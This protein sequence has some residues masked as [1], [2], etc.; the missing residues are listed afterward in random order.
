MS[1]D[2]QLYLE[3]ARTVQH[4]LSMAGCDYHLSTVGPFYIKHG[5]ASITVLNVMVLED[6]DFVI[7]FEYPGYKPG[8]RDV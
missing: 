5:Q 1:F 3:S 7:Q 6:A 4:M 8:G 2:H